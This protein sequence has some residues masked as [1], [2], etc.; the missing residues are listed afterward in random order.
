MQQHLLSHRLQ[1]T[2]LLLS[3]IPCQLQQVLHRLQLTLHIV[4]FYFLLLL[5]RQEL[6]IQLVLSLLPFL[7]FFLKSP[8]FAVPCVH[9]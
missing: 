8:Y 9:S 1:L 2:L 4:R 5:Q 7:L 3:L 6:F